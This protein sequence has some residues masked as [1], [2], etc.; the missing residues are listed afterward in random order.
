VVH[1]STI[2]RQAALPG[3]LLPGAALPLQE[4]AIHRHPEQETRQKL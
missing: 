3:Q 1:S 4:S 2:R